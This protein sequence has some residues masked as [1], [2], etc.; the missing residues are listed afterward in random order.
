MSMNV[1]ERLR[2]CD[3]DDE[4]R[5]GRGCAAVS[6]RNHRNDGVLGDRSVGLMTTSF[7]MLPASNTTMIA[8]SAVF[9]ANQTAQ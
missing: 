6:S 1:G 3:G 8:T 2:M 4:E 7:P 9:P 5:L